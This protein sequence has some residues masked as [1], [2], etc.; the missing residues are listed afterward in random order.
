MLLPWGGAPSH[1]PPLPPP[2]LPPPSPF[3]PAHYT[4]SSWTL[5]P[6]L[7]HLSQLETRR[8]PGGPG[9]RPGPSLVT[10]PASVGEKNGRIY[11][12]GKC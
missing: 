11:H 4:C 5:I 2:S 12:Q 3:V 8:N 1:P 6:S 9:A 7:A 10:R